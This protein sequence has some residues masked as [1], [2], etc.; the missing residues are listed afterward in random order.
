MRV[1]LAHQIP[2]KGEIAEALATE[3]TLILELPTN[4]LNAVV[5]GVPVLHAIMKVI[6]APWAEPLE[7]WLSIAKDFFDDLI[8]GPAV[9]EITLNLPTM[10]TPIDKHNPPV[11]IPLMHI[12][13][14]VIYK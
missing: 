12:D 13:A 8:V 1:N 4:W 2:T 6:P 7:F 11:S 3:S 9:L 10:G 14:R 5:T